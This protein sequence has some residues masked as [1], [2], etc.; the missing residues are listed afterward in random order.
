MHRAKKTAVRR[1]L[2]SNPQIIKAGPRLVRFLCGYMGKFK[3]QDLGSRLILHSH[4]PPLNS[5]P[6]VV[7]EI[8]VLSSAPYNLTGT[9]RALCPT[10][11]VLKA[12]SAS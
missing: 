3:V 8:D 1:A 6:P 7:I 5:P 2:A 11:K 10:S 12:A 9:R 4:L